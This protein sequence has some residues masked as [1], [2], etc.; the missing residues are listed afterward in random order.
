MICCNFHSLLLCLEGKFLRLHSLKL[1]QE[2]LKDRND[3]MLKKSVLNFLRSL[4]FLQFAQYLPY[5]NCNFEVYRVKD[6]Y[7]FPFPSILQNLCPFLLL[8]SLQMYLFHLLQK[9]VLS[10]INLYVYEAL[11]CIC[12]PI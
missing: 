3:F 1:F 6:R 10:L 5:Y 4:S 9:K 11:F 8:I 7:Y 12:L 2:F